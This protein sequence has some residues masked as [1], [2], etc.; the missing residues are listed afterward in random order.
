MKKQNKI[1]LFLI[2][3]FTLIF[4]LSG[5][6]NSNNDEKEKNIEDYS[7]IIGNW[8]DKNCSS[9]GP[10]YINLNESFTYGDEGGIWYRNESILYLTYKPDNITLSYEISFKKDY[11]N[12]LL[13]DLYDQELYYF[14]RE[15]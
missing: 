12:L 7:Y 3:L 11:D 9:C 15:K 4:L 8:I 6:I 1:K 13:I 2:I 10:L 14:E 5:C